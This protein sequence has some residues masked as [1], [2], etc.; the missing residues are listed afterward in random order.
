[1]AYGQVIER[2]FGVEEVKGEALKVVSDDVIQKVPQGH[3]EGGGC[4]LTYSRLKGDQK[5]LLPWRKA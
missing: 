1:M 4:S 2:H 3:Y 5:K